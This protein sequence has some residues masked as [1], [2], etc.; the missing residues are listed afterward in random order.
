MFCAVFET[1]GENG[2]FLIYAD[3]KDKTKG[4]ILVELGRQSFDETVNSGVKTRGIES[5]DDLHKRVGWYCEHCQHM[6]S[7][8][9]NCNTP[10]CYWVPKAFADDLV[11]EPVSVK[12]T[13]N[14]CQSKHVWPNNRVEC[15]PHVYPDGERCGRPPLRKKKLTIYNPESQATSK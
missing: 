15:C 7:T 1:P 8:A 14:S 11:V 6:V 9:N 3:T 5:E 13:V 12:R 2:L 4:E 10:D